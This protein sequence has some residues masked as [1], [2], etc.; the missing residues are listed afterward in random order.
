MR[1]LIV[2]LSSMGDLVL[3]FPALTDAMNAIPGIRFDWVVDQSFADVPLWH[4]G[5][6]HII[7]S[8]HRAWRRDI[9]QTIL[10]GE[11]KKFFKELRNKEYDFV[12]D[13]H[14]QWKSAIVTRLAKGTRC[15]YDRYSVIESGAQ[16]AYQKKYHVPSD[17]HVLKR[18]RQLVAQALGYSY[19]DNEPDY[20]ID[21][22]RF[23]EPGIQLP[24]PYLIFIHS[25]SW[26]SKCWPEHYWQVLIKKAADAGFSVILPWGSVGEQQKAMRIADQHKHVMV[27]PNLNLSQKAYIIEHAHA[28]I[29]CDTGLSHIAAALGKPSV[30]LYGPTDPLQT[31]NMGKNQIN[32]LSAFECVKCNK[33]ICHYNK[34]MSVPSSCLNEITP[35]FVWKQFESL[36]T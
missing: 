24:K 12:I 10:G 6:D 11:F 21:S 13:V 4:K 25:T 27:L 23:Q 35:E 30:N 1:I 5:V 26:Q 19:Q 17:Q 18:I 20:S 29:G 7:Q 2:R 32:L 8:K 36:G 9:N 3:T 16:F 22:N 28:T 34:T 33:S 15:G 14:G 31:G